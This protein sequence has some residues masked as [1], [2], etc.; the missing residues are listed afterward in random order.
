M[1]INILITVQNGNLRVREKFLCGS[2]TYEAGA[3]TT[4]R[5]ISSK[6]CFIAAGFIGQPPQNLYF[7]GRSPHFFADLSSFLYVY[8]AKK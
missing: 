8:G 4:S 6:I 7:K 3:D 5:S 2:Y 1:P